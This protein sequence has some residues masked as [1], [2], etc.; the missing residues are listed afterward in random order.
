MAR[1]K[2]LLATR[3][4]S[5]PDSRRPSCIRNTRSTWRAPSPRRASPA[6]TSRRRAGNS[7]PGSRISVSAV[8]V[9]RLPVGS[10]ASSSCGTLIDAARWPRAGVRRR[11]SRR[12]DGLGAPPSRPLPSRRAAACRSRSLRPGRSSAI[13]RF[14][15]PFATRS[16]GTTGR[17]CP[18]LSN[19][20]GRVD[21]W[22]V[23]QVEAGYRR[24]RPK[25]A[26]R[27]RRGC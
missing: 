10:S 17:S 13:R 15:T 24:R 9:S 26:G 2:P 11:T 12:D 25:W 5:I 6:A 8:S 14:A 19:G 21:G 22:S 1:S 16:G 4:V 3:L 27:V 20:N 7:H 18:P 23:R